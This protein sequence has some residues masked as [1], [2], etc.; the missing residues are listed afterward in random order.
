L[1]VVLASLVA[2]VGGATT[3]LEGPRLVSGGSNAVTD[4][5]TIAVDSIVVV[6]KKFPGI[7]PVYMAIAQGA[8]YDAVIA[9]EGGYSPYA[10]HI[11]APENSSPEAATAAAGHDALVGMFPDQEEG[12]DAIYASYLA[13]IPDGEA[14]DN[15]IIVG[16]QAAARIL[17]LRADDGRD[18]VV[19]W[20]PPPP[21]PGVY[22]PTG[23]PPPV[24]L[25]MPFITP[26]T[27]DSASQ[28]RPQGPDR[29]ESKAY[30]ED[31]NEV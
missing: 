5:A 28:F 6:A 26:F 23:P 27:L 8:V 14:K 15:G 20:V 7:A 25:N 16:Q 22:E 19:E 30:A 3:R 12:L 9:I 13:G 18:D 1:A 17:E 24:G 4:W 31:F 2:P 10:T 21:G 29:L 11:D